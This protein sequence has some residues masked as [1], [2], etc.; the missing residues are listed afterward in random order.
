[1]PCELDHCH[2]SESNRWAKFQDFFYA[3]LNITA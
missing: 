1:V 3:Q 2:G